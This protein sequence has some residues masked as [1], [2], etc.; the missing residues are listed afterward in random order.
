MRKTANSP[1]ESD[2]KGIVAG[3]P[4]AKVD[5][6][7]VRPSLILNDMP[8]AMLAVA[9][10]ATYGADKYDKYGEGGWL[11]VEGG[12]ARYTDAMDRHRI[13]EG[14]ESHDPDSE[15]LHA[16]HLAWNALARLELMLKDQP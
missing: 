4:G 11:E 12:V 7:K 10:I 1:K 13:K 9:E 3:Q 6:G 15:M 2:P 5:A 8:R 16:A 14:I